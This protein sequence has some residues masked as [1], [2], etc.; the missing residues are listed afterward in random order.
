M[1]GRYQ[2]LEV[3]EHQCDGKVHPQQ[4]RQSQ[5]FDE[6]GLQMSIECLLPLMKTKFEIIQKFLTYFSSSSSSSLSD[7]HKSLHQK[8]KRGI[9]D[10]GRNKT[11]IS[12]ADTDLGR[13]K[14]TKVP[15]HSSSP[16]LPRK[17]EKNTDPE[18]QTK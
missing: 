4:D 2:I 17:K 10:H 8:H 16:P 11:K 14:K 5:E 18:T 7:I 3:L 6:K 1:L 12:T 9:R 15:S 13:R